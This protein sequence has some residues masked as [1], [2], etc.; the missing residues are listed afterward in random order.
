MN[1][2]VKLIKKNKKSK[3]PELKWWEKQALE[4][5]ALRASVGVQA[6]DGLKTL[7]QM[8]QGNEIQKA[9]AKCYNNMS[10]DVADALVSMYASNPTL[11]SLMKKAEWA[12]LGIVADNTRSEKLPENPEEIS[13]KNPKK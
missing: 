9:L 3:E 11:A 2:I 5:D 8:R 10:A 6:G 4:C 7:A 13:E 12:H 1:K